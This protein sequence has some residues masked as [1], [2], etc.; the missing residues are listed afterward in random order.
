MAAAKS[1][2]VT[3]E[4][5]MALQVED[6]VASGA[7]ASASDVVADALNRWRE[8][9]ALESD[10][11]VLRRLWREGLD[12]GEAEVLDMA[13]VKRAARR[14]RLLEEQAGQR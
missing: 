8:Q 6:A 4:P 11:E 13:E 2:S 7:Y 14:A 12:S 1:L 9:R 5:D 3:L 10:P